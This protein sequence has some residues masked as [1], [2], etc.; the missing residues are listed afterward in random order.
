MAADERGLQ[1]RCIYRLAE[2]AG[3][4]E[5]Y[6]FKHEW[7]F[8]VFEGLPI[9][10]VMCVFCIWHPGASLGRDGGKALAREDETELSSA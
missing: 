10:I 3:G 1:I 8:W 4:V 9:L 6:V 2:F 5:G 7:L